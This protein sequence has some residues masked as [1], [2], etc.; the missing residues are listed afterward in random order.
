MVRRRFK[1]SAACVVITGVPG[2]GKTTVSRLVAAQLPR[3]ARISGDEIA[4][5]IVSG[6]VWP[7]GEPAE[8]AAAQASLTLNNIAALAR[9]VTEAGF[10]AVI[11]VVLET[12]EQLSALTNNLE[13]D[14]FLLV[15]S[16][17]SEVARARN[18]GRDAAER[19]DFDGYESLDARMKTNFKELGETLDTSDLTAQDV[20]TAVVDRFFTV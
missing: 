19:W 10:V 9:N 15:L 17:S 6:R 3:A 4:E 20:A 5:I 11:D 1:G 8:E 14:A 13:G 7:L 12:R 16:P 18:E 2:A